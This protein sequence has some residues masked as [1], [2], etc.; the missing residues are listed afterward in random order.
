MERKG[1]EWRGE[2]KERRELGL[3]QWGQGSSGGWGSVC[4]G[5][6]GTQQL[7]TCSLS[8]HFLSSLACE[9]EEW[10][11][12]WS[13]R[14]LACCCGR[15]RVPPWWLLLLM[16]GAAPEARASSCVWAATPDSDRLP[17]SANALAA[18]GAAREAAAG[19]L[20]LYRGV[21]VHRVPNHPLYLSVPPPTHTQVWPSGEWKGECGAATEPADSGGVARGVG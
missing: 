5:R 10:P 8:C 13:W 11:P 9:R 15:L 21:P 19:G 1:K 20:C 4:R 16:A 7:P 18:C 3:Q 12:C 14:S 2:R 6:P 17:L